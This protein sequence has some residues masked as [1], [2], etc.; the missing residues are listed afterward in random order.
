[1]NILNLIF[2]IATLFLLILLFLIV[3]GGILVA[4][5]LIWEELFGESF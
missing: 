3:V 2:V 1:M 5:K 4:L